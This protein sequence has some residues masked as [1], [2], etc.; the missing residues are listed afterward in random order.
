MTVTALP[1]PIRQVPAP[2]PLAGTPTE[3]HPALRRWSWLGVLALGVVAYLVVLQTMLSTQNANYFPSLLLI[4]AITVPM[5]TLVFAATGGRAQVPTSTGLLVF[6]AVVGG[7]VGTLAAGAVE[8][9]TLRNLS[10]VPMLA[11][12]L[13]EETAKLAVPLAVYLLLRHRDPR[14]G[15]LIGIA[16]GMGFATLETMGYGF[17]VLLAAH[18]IAAVDTTL[19]TRALLAPAGHIAWTGMTVAMLWRIRSAPHR[20]RAVW[21]FVA[22]FAGAVLLHAAW[23][24]ASSV[25]LRAVVAVVGLIALLVVVHRS[26]R[27]GGTARR[28]HLGRRPTVPDLPGPA[29]VPALETWASA[30]VDLRVVDDTGYWAVQPPSTGRTVPVTIPA[31]GEAR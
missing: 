11:V 17:Q 7:L 5:A 10:T 16:S 29:T 13:I 30:P 24:S 31:D 25:A 21:A 15:V 14:E 9:D 22:T 1:A 27:A 20:G 4:G 3:R 28:W 8:Y 6:T 12:G 23:D 2:V 19:L 26:H 18:S